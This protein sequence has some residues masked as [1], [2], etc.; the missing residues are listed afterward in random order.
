MGEHSPSLLAI[1]VSWKTMSEEYGAWT[2]RSTII[3]DSKSRSWY[4]QY[5][6]THQR[7]CAKHY[8]CSACL[9]D[10]IS[11]YVLESTETICAIDNLYIET[12]CSQY[13]QN[14]LTLPQLF[15]TEKTLAIVYLGIQINGFTASPSYTLYE[16][17]KTRIISFHEPIQ[18]SIADS[19][20]LHTPKLIL[21]YF[22]QNRKIK[23]SFIILTGL[24]NGDSFYKMLNSFKKHTPP[25]KDTE[26]ITVINGSSDQSITNTYRSLGLGYNLKNNSLSWEPRHFRRLQRR[27]WCS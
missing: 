2:Y 25:N 10:L 24:N 17:L 4:F 18:T 13:C 15:E 27:N 22:K 11:F 7:A 19:C 23:I 12:D 26:V 5:H 21:P 1:G 14:S 9:F 8:S 20:A 3:W 6:Q 16:K